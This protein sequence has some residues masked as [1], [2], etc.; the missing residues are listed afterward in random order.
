MVNG[1][2]PNDAAYTLN[3]ASTLRD[4]PIFNRFIGIRANIEATDNPPAGRID[5][6]PAAN[7]ASESSW[8]RSTQRSVTCEG[9]Y[10]QAEVRSTEHRLVLR[11][12]RE[13]R[14]L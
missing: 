10:C 3:F 11:D 1:S 9:E 4:S 14:A 8:I 2:Y 7:L 5:C 12:E 6:I 13:F